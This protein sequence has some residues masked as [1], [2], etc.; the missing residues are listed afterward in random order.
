MRGEKTV[1]T[2]GSFL[3]FFFFFSADE[4]RYLARER[5]KD[6][7][8]NFLINSVMRAGRRAEIVVFFFFSAALPFKRRQNSNPM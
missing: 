2:T 3:S 4:T 5:I 1:E 8:G 6:R 7:K